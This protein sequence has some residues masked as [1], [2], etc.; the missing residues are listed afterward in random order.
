MSDARIET[1]GLEFRPVAGRDVDG[2]DTIFGVAAGAAVC[3]AR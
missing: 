2:V 1:A 3:G